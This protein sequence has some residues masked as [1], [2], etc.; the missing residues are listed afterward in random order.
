MLQNNSYFKVRNA[1]FRVNYLVIGCP[2]SVAN[3]PLKNTFSPSLERFSI[4][5]V[6]PAF[7]LYP[8]L[9]RK[10]VKSTIHVPRDRDSFVQ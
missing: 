8:W 4:P 7:L 1:Y 6:R 3:D 5:G 9:I 10:H 2:L